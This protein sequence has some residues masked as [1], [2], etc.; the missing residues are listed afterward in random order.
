MTSSTRTALP[1]VHRDERSLPGAAAVI[2]LLALLALGLGFT[3]PRSAAAQD[4]N[5]VVQ[6]GEDGAL[7]VEPGAELEVPVIVDL[8]GAGALDVASLAGTITWNTDA[9]TF[10]SS[11]AGS[12]GTVN[13]GTGDAANGVVTFDASSS[14]GATETFTLGTLTFQ[15]SSSASPTGAGFEL[16]VTEASD[17]SGAS[18][19]ADLYTRGASLCVGEA[20]SLGDANGDDTIDVI[21]A[22]QIARST[23]GLEVADSAALVEFGDVNGDGAVDIIDAQQV[24]TFA[25]GLPV[26]SD[27]GQQVPID[28]N[29]TPLPAIQSPAEGAVA[30]ATADVTFQGK[31]SDPEDGEIT[32]ADLVWTSDLDG[33]IGTGGSFTA[34]ASGL[35]TGV[36]EISLTATDGDG[37]TGTARIAVEISGGM[38]ATGVDTIQGDLLADRTLFNDTTYVLD[39]PVFVGTDC[40]PDG[41]APDC[42]PVTLT[43]EPGTTLTGLREPTQQGVRGSM[44]VV[45]RGSEIIADAHNPDFG[46][47]GVCERPDEEDVIV[48]TSDAPRGQRARGDWGGLVL[49]GQARLNVGQEAQ[50]EGDS[51]LFGGDDDLDS[52]GI[53]R[54]VRV[55][56]AGDDVT[57][58]DQL[59]GIAFQGSGAGTTV[60]YVQVHYNQDDGYEPFGGT[61]SVTHLV[62]TGIGDDSFDGTDGWRGFWQFGIGQQRGDDADQ[63][64]E[65]S[66]NGDDPGASPNTTGVVSNF[67]LIG[68]GLNLGTGEI[69][70]EGG[71]SDMGILFR[72]G[73]NWRVFNTVA[74][75]FGASGFDVEGPITAQNADNRLGGSTDVN[76]TLRLES[77]VL[78]SNVA[79]GGGV[80]NFADASGDGFTQA[81][82]QNFFEAAGFNNLLADPL[83]SDDAFSIGTRTSPPNVIATGTPDG[84]TAFDV[85]TLNGGPGLVMPTDGRTLQSVSYPGAVEPGTP[86]ADAWYFGWTVWTV[87]G[88]DSRPNA[89]GQ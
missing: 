52:S 20:G 17:E 14:M 83:L 57:V 19:L 11:A 37:A 16:R 86:L 9:A 59:N 58:A 44:L 45:S 81:E 48:F 25:I 34:N 54:G 36:H 88:E 40:G 56:Y 53:L 82:N 21:D 43:I 38:G 70:A 46:G 27:V 66:N 6:L 76:S 7:T 30:G 62:S 4:P 77:S 35:S 8:S 2:A 3:T 39:G 60:C 78:W 74:S 12:F 33:Q 75:G 79:V 22:Q 32:G 26:T 18:L 5:V 73:A 61:T 24:A 23:V 15:G 28:C 64:F 87:G 13:F 29:F 89:E 68:A 63:G 50:G 49:N 85:S 69:F 41:S 84:F 80:E 1:A 55:E 72:E 10:S 67:T 51:G 31:A 47:S 71:E 65:L 42:T